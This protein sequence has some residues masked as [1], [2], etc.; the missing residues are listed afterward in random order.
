MIL[1]L[2]FVIKIAV[3]LKLVMQF[4]CHFRLRNFNIFLI[5]DNKN[6]IRLGVTINKSKWG[7]NLAVVSPGS[8][9]YIHMDIATL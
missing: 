1:D 4:R 2:L 5:I 9:G 6:S 3:T 7:Q 8:G